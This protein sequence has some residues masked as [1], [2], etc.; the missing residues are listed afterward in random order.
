MNLFKKRKKR[1]RANSIS[2]IHPYLDEGEWCFDDP[3]V[4]LER[5]PFVAGMDMIIDRAVMEMDDPGGGFTLLFSDSPFPSA[6]PLK[7]IEEESGGNWYECAE[8]G[9]SGWCCPALLKYF[10]S[11][12]KEIYF[13]AKERG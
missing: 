4:G 12:P 10:D 13:Q 6:T 8:Y 7:W 3:S 2:V 5:E 1:T 11:A 9:L